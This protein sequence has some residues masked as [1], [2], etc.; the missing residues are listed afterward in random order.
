MIVPDDVTFAAMCFAL[1]N[2]SKIVSVTL[3][4]KGG[5]IVDVESQPTLDNLDISFKWQ[6][7][8]ELAGLAVV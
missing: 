8:T 1:L 3:C 7:K 4:G 2:E 6:S 5:M